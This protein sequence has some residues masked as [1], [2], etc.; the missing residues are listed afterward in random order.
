MAVLVLIAMASVASAVELQNELIAYWNFDD[1]LGT[2]LRDTAPFGSI[3]DNG[4][5]RAGT[6]PTWINGRFGSA[7]SFDGASNYVSIP[8]SADLS[9][10][11]STMTIAGW[12]NLDTLP[13]ALPST[14][15]GIYDSTSDAY[16]VYL[17]KNAQELRC[18]VS[19]AS[20]S[21]ARPGVPLTSLSTGG[22]HHVAAVYDGSGT[23][24]TAKIY[25]DGQLK[26]THTGDDTS[27]VGL[28][29]NIPAGQAA[30]IGHDAAVGSPNYFPGDVD[31]WGIWKRALSDAEIAYIAGGHA[32]G[33]SA[34]V[35][36]W[37]LD[38]DLTNSGTGGTAFGGTLVDGT[39]GTH[40]Y[41]S[42]QFGQGLD[43][44]HPSPRTGSAAGNT[45]DGDY[46]RSDYQP[47][48][49]GTIALWYYAVPWYD[50][51]S[52][53]DNS[54]NPDDWEFWIYSWGEAKFRIESGSDVSF[55]LD[56]LGGPNHWYHLAV[57]WQRQAGDSTKV[58]TQLFVNGVL[59]SSKTGGPWID[60]GKF[61]LGGGNNG[62]TYGTGAWDD[63]RIYE[64]AL[65]AEELYTIANVPE[66]ATWMLL[67]VG[68]MAWVAIGRRRK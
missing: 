45:T 19:D 41:T 16:V 33:E 18:K 4:T 52:I 60:P 26:D 51:Q 15:A 8:R 13:A 30:E 6:P 42:G 1:G 20:G 68:G 7:L 29:G 66:P 62:N 28:T 3:A 53:F 44:G 35:V 59:R 25:W 34:P 48:N 47:A 27:H 43:L 40:A 54:A 58:D 65:S 38:G 55:D 21:M 22:W 64:R 67:T 39:S 57:T 11:S 46:I 14:F 9:I 12:V 5:L 10:G 56:N 17:D 2:G 24:G 50:Y 23:V 32:L 37:K 61:L 63:V 31:D 49:A 36:H